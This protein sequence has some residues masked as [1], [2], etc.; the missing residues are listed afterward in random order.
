MLRRS[1]TTDK[2]D[3]LSGHAYIFLLLNLVIGLAAVG[4]L[5]VRA[6][7]QIETRRW[8]RYLNDSLHDWAG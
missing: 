7:T 2:A 3:L 1:D 6:R 5:W 8:M 4:L